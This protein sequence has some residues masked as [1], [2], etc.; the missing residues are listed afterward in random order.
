MVHRIFVRR[1]RCRR[2]G[3]GDALL[4]DCVLR[5]R[6]DSTSSVGAAVLAHTGHTVPDTAWVLYQHV[7][8]R[9]VRSWRQRFAEQ[10]DELAVRFT[11]LCVEWGGTLPRP[12]PT[13]AGRS[14]TAI[15]ATWQ[16]AARRASDI[17]PPWRLA[18]VI[19]GSQLLSGR[20]DLP[21]PIVPCMIGRSRGP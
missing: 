3:S 6:L 1:V 10:A 18:N 17:P 7:P 21:W 11:A 8:A 20:V 14:I 15:G 5:N 2:C 4:A 16:A 12:A 13:P 9:T 19:V